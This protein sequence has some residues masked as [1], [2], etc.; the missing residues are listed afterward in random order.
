MGDGLKNN[1][2]NLSVSED[3][4]KCLVIVLTSALSM[5]VYLP[6]FLAREQLPDWVVILLDPRLVISGVLLIGLSV[7][8]CA[9]VMRKHS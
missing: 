6:L 9:R 5:L 4:S 3:V 7:Y 1:D 2:T 8:I